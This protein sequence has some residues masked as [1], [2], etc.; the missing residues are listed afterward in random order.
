MDEIESR[1]NPNIWLAIHAQGWVWSAV[2]D[3]V[4]R[5]NETEIASVAARIL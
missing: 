1:P 5:I 4:L 3:E 2:V